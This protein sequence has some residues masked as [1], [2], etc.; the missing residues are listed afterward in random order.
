MGGE[1]APHIPITLGVCPSPDSSFWPFTFAPS[2]SALHPYAGLPMCALHDVRGQALERLV[3]EELERA[4]FHL[5]PSPYPA[6]GPWALSTRFL[7]ARWFRWLAQ[8]G[9]GDATKIGRVCWT[10]ELVSAEVEHVDSPSCWRILFET[11]FKEFEFD[12]ISAFREFA[13]CCL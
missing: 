9:R 7:A 8:K 2:F 5:G 3:D 10:F 12:L 6:Q 11:C 4:G 13:Y 1:G